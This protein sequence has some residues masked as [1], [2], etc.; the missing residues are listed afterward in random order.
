MD[1]RRRRGEGGGG[2][3]GEGR[4]D[5][6]E[7]GER[8][9]HDSCHSD[10]YHLQTEHCLHADVQGRDIEGLKQNLEEDITR[11]EEC[12]EHNLHVGNNLTHLRCF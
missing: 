1:K 5:R 4:V 7:G 8:G 11:E 12:Q 10:L 9:G 2:G 3:R 6:E